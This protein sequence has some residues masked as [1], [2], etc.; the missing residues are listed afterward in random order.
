MRG[1]GLERGTTVHSRRRKELAIATPDAPQAAQPAASDASPKKRSFRPGPLLLQA[2]ALAGAIGSIVGLLFTFVPSLRPGGSDNGNSVSA[3]IPGTNDKATLSVEADAVR[4]LTWGDFQREDG[5]PRK[6]WTGDPRQPGVT[7]RFGLE[8]PGYPK[9]T[10]FS[11]RY[12]LYRIEA[13]KSL[14][15]W[16]Q[17]EKVRMDADG[18]SCA[19]T[20]D[21]IGVP[22]RNAIYRVDVAVFQPQAKFSEPVVE[23][24]TAP[25]AT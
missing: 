25:F 6:Y 8:F 12:K 15:V 20:S 19:C 4:Q 2:G 11:I 14:F 17:R 22:R 10:L 13:S 5:T 3:P 1:R 24:S 18:D 21:F 9:G 7:I 16:Q 23:N